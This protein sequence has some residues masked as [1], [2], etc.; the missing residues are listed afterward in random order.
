MNYFDRYQAFRLNGSMEPIVF[1]PIEEVDTDKKVKYRVGKT[2]LDDLSDRY[3]NNPYSG[4]LI[5]MANPGL[6][7]L[8]FKFTDDTLIRIPFPYESALAR[9]QA[10]VKR[11]KELYG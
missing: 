5:V 11:H 10:A 7:S 9:Y 4:Y 3:Y 8:E 1:F 6:G 2:R